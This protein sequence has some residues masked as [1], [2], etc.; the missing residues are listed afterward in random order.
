MNIDDKYMKMGRS[1]LN[2]FICKTANNL[3]EDKTLNILD[4]GP[5]KTE[6]VRKNH[7]KDNYFTFDIE[8]S[9]NP[10]FVG[11]I[12]KF[13]PLIKD[14]SFD[15]IYCLEVLEHTL[16]PFDAITELK[17]ILKDSSYLVLSAPL[18]MRIHG[19]IPDCWRFT[20]FGW[21]VLLKDFEIIKIEKLNCPDR[22]LF[23][24]K[25]NLIAR[26]TNQLKS[27]D[28]LKFDKLK[29]E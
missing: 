11:D 23:P 25:Y 15:I 16:N 3:R 6:I 1:H 24:I 27:I 12:T 28:D 22:P 10:D 29:Y 17:R 19:P 5:Q 4:I 18:N 7:L 20:E 26:K 21:R 8:P 2:D 14:N 9:N 13:N